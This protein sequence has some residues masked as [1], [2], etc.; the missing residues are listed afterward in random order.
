[1]TMDRLNPIGQNQTENQSS[2]TLGLMYARDD[3]FSVWFWPIGFSLSIVIGILISLFERRA[4]GAPEPLTYREVMRQ[5]RQDTET[6]E[7]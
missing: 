2:I 7:S 1:M 6:E 3:W 4:P 5:T